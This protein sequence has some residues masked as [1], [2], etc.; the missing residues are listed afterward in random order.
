M[1]HHFSFRF[2]KQLWTCRSRHGSLY[3][4]LFELKAKG[5]TRGAQSGGICL[6]FFLLGQGTPKG[7][8]H[9]FVF[10]GGSPYSEH[11][12]CGWT[13]KETYRSACFATYSSN[14]LDGQNP[15]RTSL[16]RSFYLM[17]QGFIYPW[18]ILS[19][20]SC[21]LSFWGQRDPN[22]FPKQ[23]QGSEGFDLS[24]EGSPISQNIVR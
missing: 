2:A 9:V 18:R 8:P 17:S 4:E 23:F 7:K 20:S 12:D 16:F 6:F 24:F 15:V 13:R 11:K 22:S 21:P 14:H 1:G 5:K 10:G 3:Q 19:N